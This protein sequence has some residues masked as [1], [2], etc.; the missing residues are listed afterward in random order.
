M[1]T[2]SLNI[3]GQLTPGDVVGVSYN[4]CIVFGW[5]VDGGQYG[6]LKYIA[7]KVPAQIEQQHSDFLNMTPQPTWLS[8]KYSKGIQFR[9]FRRDFI[10]KFSPLDNRAFKVANPEEF[11]KGTAQEADYIANRKILNDHKFP[12]K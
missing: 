8:K 10:V 5:Y 3:G 11:F 1:K 2:T 9:H 12:A 4:N 7:L 6:S